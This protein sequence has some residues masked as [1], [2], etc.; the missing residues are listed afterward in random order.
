MLRRLLTRNPP[1]LGLFLVTFVWILWFATKIHVYFVVPD[2][3]RYVMQAVDISARFRPVMPGDPDFATWSQL[4]PALMAP[5][6]GLFQ[7]PK[8]YQLTH[9]LNA[10]VMA[11]SVFPAYLLTLRVLHRRA[12]ALVGAALVVLV[13]WTVMAGVMMTEVSAYPLAIWAYYG[14]QRAATGSGPRDD[15]IGLSLLGL[16]FFART[17]LIVLAPIL[18]I[19]LLVQGLRYP[20]AHVDRPTRRVRPQ[21]RRHWVVFGVSGLVALL[22]AVRTRTVIG[23]APE[24]L[25]SPGWAFTA[26][27]MLSYIAIGVAMLPLALSA[28]WAAGTLWRPYD[29]EQHAF[30]V[31]GTLAAILLTIV[32]GGGSVHFTAGINDR[33]LAYLVPLIMIGMLACLLERRRWRLWIVLGALGAAWIVKDAVLEQVGPT[34]VSPS[35]AWH[36]VLYGHAPQIGRWF[37]L[38]WDSAQLMTWWTIGA[39][40]AIALARTWLRPAVVTTFVVLV[41]GGY[42]FI[43]TTY[44]RSKLEKLQPAASYATGRDWVDQTLPYGAQ[45]DAVLSTLGADQASAS[46]VWWDLTFWNAQVT[47]TK[48]TQPAPTGWNDQAFPLPFTIDPDTGAVSGV[49]TH[50]YVVQ[51]VAD[52]RFAFRGAVPVGAAKNN[53]QIFQ[54]PQP[55]NALWTWAG[56]DETGFLPPGGTATVRVFADGLA[57]R[58]GVALALGTPFNAQGRSKYRVSA[59][60]G[61]TVTGKVAIDQQALPSIE[62]DMPA[63]GHIDLTLTALGKT[64]GVQFYAAGIGP[65]LTAP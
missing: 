55:V 2:E 41:V 29:A 5:L 38:T 45:A 20:V 3:V 15:L 52:R 23:N 11:S 46:A 42:G 32:V 56:P 54:I 7:T 51:G 17:Q 39:C 33:Y 21:L 63:T 40:V 60:G 36:F 6:W 64:Q 44:T 22:F 57:G 58:R 61:A 4:Q 19:V 26:R 35:A 47:G 18:P 12:W 37:G 24:E 8:A 9:W 10:F 62:L 31:I 53:L 65:V 48:F 27:E 13:P 30:A 28:A 14:L 59:A 1:L 50:G 25:F 34:F 49:G 43:E 16:A